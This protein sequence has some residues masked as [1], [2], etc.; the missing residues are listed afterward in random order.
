LLR[1]Y[2]SGTAR[3]GYNKESAAQIFGFSAED[4]SR[5]DFTYPF[6]MG[7]DFARP[8]SD[9]SLDIPTNDPSYDIYAHPSRQGPA[10]QGHRKVHDYHSLGVVLETG[11]WQG[12]AKMVA[13]RNAA[14]KRRGTKELLD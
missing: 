13:D 14:C 12:A 8:D 5:I 1:R 7:F 9:L 3:V 6:I 10:R 4:N 11:L 2:T